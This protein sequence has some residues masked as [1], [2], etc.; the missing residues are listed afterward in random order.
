M[1]GGDT[2]MEEASY[3]AKLC[4]SVTIIHRRDAFRASKIMQERI[5]QNPKIRVLWDSVV[6]EVLGDGKGVTGLKVRNVKT[7]AC[8]ELE[9]QGLFVAIGHFP[10]TE[11]VREHLEMQPNGYVRTVPGTT[12]TSIPGVFACG[13]VQDPFYRQAITAAGT[14]C[15]AA[16]DAERWM[17]EQGEG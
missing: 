13:D 2:A 6:D 11:L 10:N 17:I 14:G 3:L 8:K 12:R 7:D 4:K 5:L 15:M 1:G 16:I 9:L